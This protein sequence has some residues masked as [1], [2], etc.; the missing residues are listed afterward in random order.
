[1]LSAFIFN[2][3][4]YI[5]WFNSV[6]CNVF[7]SDSICFWLSSSPFLTALELIKYVLLFYLLYRL[8]S[9]ISLN[10][11]FVSFP[12]G[13]DMHLNQVYLDSVL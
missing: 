8:F 5:V 9:H 12:R 2:I 13:N 7:F 4:N 11:N 1:M 10:Y 6:I 3:I